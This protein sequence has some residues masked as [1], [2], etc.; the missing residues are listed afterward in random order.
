MGINLSLLAGAAILVPFVAALLIIMCPQRAAK[1]LSIA[2]GVI[3]TAASIVAWAMLAYSGGEPLSIS[4][5]SIMNLEFIGFIFDKVSVMLAAC[6]VAIGLI[7]T[8]YSVG[9][10]TKDNREHADVHSRRFYA[11]FTVFIG[12]IAGLVY[13]STLVGM[14]IFFEITGACSWALIR[15]YG[16]D[17]ANKA[18]MKAL[19]ITHI[20]SLGLFIAIGLLFLQTGS[21]TVAAIAGLGDAW[22]SA[23]II[24]IIIAAWAKS[25][26][27]P[28]YMWLPSA[29]EA[30]TPVSAY[31]PRRYPPIFM[32]R[33]WSRWALPLW[34]GCW[35]RRG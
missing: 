35:Y 29:M 6:F 16:T 21:F 13:S 19:I 23:I 28:F 32:V 31:L 2:A 9:Y 20:G 18:A 25:A 15:H 27:L 26:Q 14:L 34:R 11:A 33:P 1:G 22:K 30:P 3:A 12:A 10:L 7:I 4:I 5:F 8:I 24:C 17:T